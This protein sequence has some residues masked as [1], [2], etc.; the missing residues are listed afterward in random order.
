MPHKT[1]PPR[2]DLRLARMLAD[3][4]HDY[5]STSGD[6]GRVFVLLFVL[7]S[8]FVPVLLHSRV[9]GRVAAGRPD[10]KSQRRNRY[11]QSIDRRASSQ[12]VSGKKAVKS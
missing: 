8:L 11:S 9:A 7:L 6:N 12:R 3:E 4:G 10:S 5:A 1:G 2:D